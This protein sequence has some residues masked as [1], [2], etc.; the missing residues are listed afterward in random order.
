MNTLMT[1]QRQI[2]IV[3]LGNTLLSDD[4]AGIYVV[5]EMR[6]ILSSSSIVFREVAA[7]GLE[8]LEIIS[9][10]NQVILVDA[11]QT[12][13]NDAGALIE[14]EL[15]DL[16]GGSAM[17]RHHVSLAEAIELGR[18]LGIPLPERLSIYGIEVTDTRT[19]RESCT[20]TVAVRIKEIARTI[21]E[22]ENLV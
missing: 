2:L 12:F 5:R 14:L 22:R 21:I 10:F 19:F 11:V 4:G 20:E 9:G 13:Q 18:T 6:Q 16:K 7:G 17:T 8:I 1:G 3:G 15:E